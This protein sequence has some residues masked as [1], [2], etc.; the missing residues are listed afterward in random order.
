MRCFLV[1]SVLLSFIAL[2][3]Y[4]VEADMDVRS[5]RSIKVKER[6]QS[7]LDRAS[8]EN[9][10]LSSWPRDVVSETASL[11]KMISL[12]PSCLPYLMER[13]GKTG[14]EFELLWVA[15]EILKLPPESVSGSTVATFRKSLESKVRNGYK[16]AGDKFPILKGKW[17]ETKR[18]AE[19]L[20]LWHD[21]TALDPEFRILRTERQLT[22]LGEVYTEIQNLG[23][24]V[25]PLLM[26]E[27]KKGEYDFLPII[28]SLTN[29]AAP[30][31]GCRPVDDAANALKWWGKHSAEWTVDVS[32]LPSERGS[33][34]DQED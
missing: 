11:R 29:G 32:Q 13:R 5:E 2:S 1:K 18:E 24:F 28:G 30:L 34:D 14:L 20:A 12:G 6:F 4:G 9:V 23:V 27:V 8:K 19:T 21:I 25:L 10:S 33:P 15:V 17:S 22:P 31:D 26:E 7:L 3:A 16:E